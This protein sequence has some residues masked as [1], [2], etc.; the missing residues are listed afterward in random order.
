MLDVGCQSEKKWECSE[1]KIVNLDRSRLFRIVKLY[2]LQT[3][4]NKDCEAYKS[5]DFFQHRHIF[6]ID[7]W[8]AF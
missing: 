8:T 4:G 2:S 6:P 7:S 1:K 5:V 3:E